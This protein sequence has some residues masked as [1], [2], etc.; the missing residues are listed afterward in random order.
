MEILYTINGV[1]HIENIDAWN[2][3]KRIAEIYEIADDVR[4]PDEERY[5]NKDAYHSMENEGSGY[6]VT[7]YCSAYC[8]KDQITRKLFKEAGDALNRL[9]EHLKKS[10]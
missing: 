3:R 4:V 10:I 6:F 5:D 8:F 7:G 1:E 9:E 2:N